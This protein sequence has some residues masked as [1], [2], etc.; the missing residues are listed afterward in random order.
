MKLMRV[1]GRRGRKLVMLTAY[2]YPTARLVDEASVDL[3]LVGDSLGMVVLGYE[4]TAPV[5]M[6]EM[7]HHARAVRR[8]V[9]RAL[10]IAD[11]PLASLRRGAA[12]VR[13]AE[14]LVREIGCDGVKV[15]WRP[16]ILTT[17]ASMVKR[18]IPVLGHVGLTPQLVTEPSGFRVQ[19]RRAEEALTI[20]QEAL[21]LER[22]G[23]FGVVLECVPD[24]VAALITRRLKIPTIGIGAGPDCD[25]Q[26][27]VLHDLLGLHHGRAARFVKQYARVGETITRAVTAYRDDVRSGRYP[28]VKHA[29]SIADDEFRRLRRLLRKNR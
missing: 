10:V 24:R 5:T 29:Y 9:R 11:L 1:A 25:G 20:L 4:T 16:G 27:L 18:R 6:Q 22:A 19:G 3:I 14:R 28:S 12:A 26:V 8:A 2:D 15:E 23:C 7:L 13:D 17:V 21:E